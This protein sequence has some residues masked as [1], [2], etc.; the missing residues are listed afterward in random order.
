MDGTAKMD[1]GDGF[2]ETDD[3]SVGYKADF[4]REPGAG[5]DAPFA[6]AYPSYVRVRE[7]ILLPPGSFSIYHPE[8]VDRSLAGMAYRRHGEIK[9]NTFSVE[10]TERSIAPEFPASEAVAAQE[11]LRTLAK[12]A[13]YVKKPDRYAM[14][15]AD[16][17]MT[18]TTAE[19]FL[20][21][22]NAFLDKGQLD[23]AIADFDKVVSL[24][25]HNVWGLADRGLAY[26]WKGDTVAANRDIDA[27][28]GIDP[29]NAV[30]FRGRALM[31]AHA[32]DLKGEIAAL[33]TALEIEPD[34]AFALRMRAQA[35]HQ[36]M[37]ND[38]AA[39]DATKLVKLLPH[40]LDLY[41]LLGNIAKAKGDKIESLRQADAVIAE[42]GDQAF[43]YVIAAQI[44]AAYGKI[45]E[46][47]HNF[48][49]AIAIKPEAYIYIN[50]SNARPK[51][52][53]AA[54]LADLDAALKLEPKSVDAMVIKANLQLDQRDPAG[55][56][57]T[58]TA[59]RATVQD[60][61]TILLQRGIAYSRLGQQAAA[62]KDF[63]AARALATNAN[64][65]N[66]SCWKKATANVALV[67]ALA[68][69][70]AALALAPDSPPILD[71]RGFAL[72]RLGRYSDAIAAYD[73]SL[74]TRGTAATSFYGRAIAESKIGNSAKAESD[75]VAALKANPDVRSQFQDYGVVAPVDLD[76]VSTSSAH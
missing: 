1:W 3:T 21:R 27:A 31:A 7:T 30:V 20:D 53:Y 22:G 36:N 17:T 69:C 8:D 32:E 44:Q 18:P 5:H 11:E 68:D 40:D 2:Y 73:K 25:A 46:A 6:V 62:D 12:Q 33:N 41:L 10:E 54:R 67:S 29:R 24:D 64:Q 45:D 56:V 50:R 37:E 72:L 71:S 15:A 26:A 49:R 74:A 19:G 4:T 23:P 28:A 9:G 35:L 55:A 59:A 76:T 14:T 60:D 70:D 48:D 34:N 39:V 52:D 51:A 63:A 42:N 57:A 38:L 16:L 61:G 47:L 43:A 65:L 66:G 75:M 13:M 58:L